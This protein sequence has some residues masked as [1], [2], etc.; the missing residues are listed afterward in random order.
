[1]S[2]LLRSFVAAADIGFPYLLTSLDTVGRNFN[3][4][5]NGS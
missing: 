4:K 5:F 1:M 3:I 2:T